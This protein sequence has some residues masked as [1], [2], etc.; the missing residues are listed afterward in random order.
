VINELSQAIGRNIR[1][2]R[3]AAGLS[4]KS[5]AARA[6]VG[7]THL[8][9]LEGGSGSSYPSVSTLAK[10]AGVLGCKVADLLHEPACETCY[11]LPPTGFSCNVCGKGQP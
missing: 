9:V 7:R 1:A 5:L 11:D 4:Q 6:D 8:T 2:R 3:E 10:L